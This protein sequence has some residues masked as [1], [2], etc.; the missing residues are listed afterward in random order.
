M[1]FSSAWLR[2]KIFKNVLPSGSIRVRLA[3]KRRKNKKNT[4]E[5]KLI[6]KYL[7]VVVVILR[8]NVNSKLNSVAL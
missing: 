7:A 5:N 8:L 4:Q 6:S 2:Q 3:E 1:D